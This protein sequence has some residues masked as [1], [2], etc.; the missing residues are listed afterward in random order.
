MIKKLVATVAIAGSLAL[1]VACGIEPT[2]TLTDFAKYSTECQQVR[3]ATVDLMMDAHY[4]KRFQGMSLGGLMDVLARSSSDPLGIQQ[5]ADLMI[6]CG[7]E[8]GT[9]IP[10]PRPL[11]PYPTPNCSLYPGLLPECPATATPAAPVVR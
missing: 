6:A 8:M 4:H 10:T 11:P 3:K 1:G 5:E 7:I 9:V 2:P